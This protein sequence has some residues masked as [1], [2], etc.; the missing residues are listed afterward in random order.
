MLV[1]GRRAAGFV[2]ILD[3]RTTLPDYDGNGMYLSA[4]NAHVCTIS[5]CH[6]VRG[7][8]LRLNGIASQSDDGSTDAVSGRKRSS[9]GAAGDGSLSELPALHP[10]LPARRAVTLS[11]NRARLVSPASPADRDDAAAV[12]RRRWP[13]SATA[14]PTHAA[15]QRRRRT[16]RRRPGPRPARG[17]PRTL[18]GRRARRPAVHDAR[19]PWRSPIPEC[20]WAALRQI[21]RQ[22]LPKAHLAERD[23]SGYPL[24]APAQAL[25][26]CSLSR[27]LIRPGSPDDAL[28]SRAVHH[29]AH[30]A[31]AW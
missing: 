28:P 24:A 16:A 7:R 15:R 8:R 3:E 23:T 6:L 29:V 25:V 12:T 2:R 9:S 21:D 30:P 26:S 14:G 17:D 19:S 1:Q 18:S 22:D 4:G 11:S 5:R 13:T 31:K 27:V 10:P 20:T